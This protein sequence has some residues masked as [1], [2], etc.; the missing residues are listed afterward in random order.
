MS[1][2]EKLQQANLKV[3]QPR[4]KIL[5]IFESMRDKHLSAEDVLTQ[6]KKQDDN[7]GIAT[8]YRVL[9]QFE[10][11]G[12]VQRLQLG[13]DHAVYELDD[14]K[15]HDHIICIKCHKISEFRDPVIQQRQKSIIEV[16]QG[17]QIIDH[18]SVVYIICKSCTAG[19]YSKHRKD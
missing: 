14:G 16:E 8:I 19:G 13:R 17:G 1:P 15:P 12:I 9:S 2:A 18:H 7:V 10:V 3:T 6:L 5:D 11:A 4:I